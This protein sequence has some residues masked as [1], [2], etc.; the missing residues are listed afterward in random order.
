[1]EGPS[2]PLLHR[3]WRFADISFD[4]AS[5]TLTV[6]N[7]AAELE[8]R[9]LKLLELLLANAG[10]IVTKS[11]IL[12]TLWAGREVTE[13]SLTNCMARLRQAM[14]EAGHAAIRTVHG[15]GYR[16]VAPVTMEFTSAGPTVLPAAVSLAAGDAVP[17]RPN[18]CLL[19][20]LGTGGYGDAW[21]AEQTK[22]RERRVMKFARDANGLAA[23]R[24]EVALGR[25]LREGLGPRAD[26]VRILDWNLAAPP[27]FIEIPWAEA[28]NLADWAAAQGGAASLPLPLRLD[29][30][31]QIA[32]ALAAIHGMAVLHKDLKPANILMRVDEA[33]RP[34]IILTD[35]GSGRALDP[36]RLDALGITRPDPDKTAP[37]SSGGTQMYRAPECSSGAAPTVQADI[38]ALGVV[39]FQ[40]AAGDL[41]RPLAPGWEEI[42]P[43]ALLREDI[44]AAAA[45]DPARRLADAAELARR[46]RALPARRA[47]RARAEQAAA[48][49]ARLR[50]DLDLARAR[51]APLLALTGALLIGF[52]T[53]TVL[54]FRAQRAQARAERAQ[55][56][57]EQDSARARSVTAF[58]TDDLF[59]AANPLLGAD[60]NVP[61][62]RVLGVAAA[63]LDRRF[64]RGNQ[65]RGA[66]EAALG[67][68]Y[69]GL[70]DADH[71]LPLLRAAL[72]DLRAQMGDND[73]QTQAVRLAM[74]TLAQHNY[75][76]PAMREAGRAMLA[77]GPR[78]A[79][80]DL[81]ARAFLAMADCGE[82]ANADACVAQFQPLFT[83]AVHRLGKQHP[84]TLS[85]ESAIAVQLGLAQHVDQSIALARE[86]AALTQAVY[87]PDH[88]LTQQRRFDLAQVLV[89]ADKRDEAIPMLIDIRRRVLAIT[90]AETDIS[91]DVADNLGMAYIFGG[92]HAESLPLFQLEF[93]Y[94]LKTRGETSRMAL[95]ALSNIASALR[96][97]GRTSESV[98]KATKVRDIFLRVSGPD[99]PD[100][101]Y[102][103]NN[104]G[105]DYRYD[106][107]FPAAEAVLRDVVARSRRVF[108]HGEYFTG[109]YECDLAEV[110]LEQHRND[111]A[112]ALLTESVASLRQSLGPTHRHT[113]HAQA[114]LASM[115]P[116]RYIDANVA[117]PDL[118]H[119]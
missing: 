119:R 72:A 95:D 28:G 83:S 54:Y 104:L 15:Y 34:G 51:R 84:V 103:G 64:P 116:T 20:R 1:M 96:Y 4:E 7:R 27:E 33:G 23:L 77:A 73:P 107:N 36:T 25:L 100:T 82:H 79:Q 74:G 10:E 22:S 6:A 105:I 115:T 80:T 85:L 49:A 3:R 8:P 70:G 75:N 19:R 29:L 46:L 45:G 11:E 53:S 97:L 14:G 40:L 106:R 43:D 37:E 89:Q 63:D 58:L 47:A 18:W 90:G 101:L 60:P 17:H 112:R 117:A 9:P 38:F 5:Q 31:A 108:T 91:V 57:A 55:Q 56:A 32:E 59:S 76:Y 24:R 87:G 13:A 94:A 65:D 2:A 111:E 39:L 68:A 109:L 99:N 61:I 67:T 113:L 88:L 62:R 98:E 66:I 50:R 26:L 12:D 69:G 93:E 114:I 102:A 30:A 110:L 44:A 118:R 48:E 52:T 71:A 21:L 86:T 42:I 41:R 16:L 81:S 35:F 92:R 78:D